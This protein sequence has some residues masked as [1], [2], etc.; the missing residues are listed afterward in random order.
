MASRLQAGREGVAAAIAGRD[1]PFGDYSQ[2]PRTEQPSRDHV[3]SPEAPR[4]ERK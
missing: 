3:I 2:A 4:F 1:G